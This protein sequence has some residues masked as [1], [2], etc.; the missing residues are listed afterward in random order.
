MFV[1]MY[2]CISPSS[3]K[4]WLACEDPII[5]FIGAVR[6]KWRKGGR[7][8]MEEGEELG[9]QRDG[10]IVVGKRKWAG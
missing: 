1:C 9:G 3:V 10:G 8:E 4:S 2:V 7:G 6:E 5:Y